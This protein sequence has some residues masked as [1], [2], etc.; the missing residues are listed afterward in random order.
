MSDTTEVAEDTT[1]AEVSVE[2]PAEEVEAAA[3]AP[4]KEKVF[5][6]VVAR[7]EA[8]GITH[9]SPKPHQEVDPSTRHR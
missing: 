5:P 2:A 4:K 6:K 9:Y 8:A 3:P 7:D 1:D